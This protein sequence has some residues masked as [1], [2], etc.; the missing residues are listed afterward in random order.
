MSLQHVGRAAATAAP[1]HAPH[2]RAPAAPQGLHSLIPVVG[3]ADVRRYVRGA[4]AAVRRSGAPPTPVLVP[5]ASRD[6][7]DA[8]TPTLRPM[9]FVPDHSGQGG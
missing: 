9:V 6:E 4:M 7:A 1:F 8:G 3:V 2:A 5:I